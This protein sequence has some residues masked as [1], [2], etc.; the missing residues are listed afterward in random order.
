MCTPP[1]ITKDL[2]KLDTINET[3]SLEEWSLTDFSLYNYFSI[4]IQPLRV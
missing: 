2:R 4:T 3:V 1:V